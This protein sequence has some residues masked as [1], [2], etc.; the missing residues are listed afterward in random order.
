MD[1]YNATTDIIPADTMLWLI[2]HSAGVIREFCQYIQLIVRYVRASDEDVKANIHNIVIE[3]CSIPSFD[4]YMPL[5]TAILS[6][7]KV[8]V[9]KSLTKLWIVGESFEDVFDTLKHMVEMFGYTS[10]K[11]GQQIYKFLMN[12]WVQYSQGYTTYRSLILSGL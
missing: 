6:D 9:L 11:S 3:I 10:Y 4:V 1:K 5:I 2:S 12:G 7:N 8:E